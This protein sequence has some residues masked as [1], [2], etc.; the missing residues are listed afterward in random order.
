MPRSDKSRT[1]GGVLQLIVPGIGRIYLGYPAI[2]VLQLILTPCGVG[3]LWSIIDGVIILAG[4][5]RMDGYGR[6]LND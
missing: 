3:W 4:G 6:Q 2:G 5:V 1:T